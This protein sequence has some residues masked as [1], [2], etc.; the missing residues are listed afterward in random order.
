MNQFG[1]FL[2]MKYS[3]P[4]VNTINVFVFTL[5][6]IG[7]EGAH[8]DTIFSLVNHNTLSLQRSVFGFQF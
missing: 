6:D 5:L 4:K 1:G 3:K 7:C 8:V 2:M